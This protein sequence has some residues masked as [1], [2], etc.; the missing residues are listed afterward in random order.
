MRAEDPASIVI[1]A[2]SMRDVAGCRADACSGA[3]PF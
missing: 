1:G 3:A 2:V